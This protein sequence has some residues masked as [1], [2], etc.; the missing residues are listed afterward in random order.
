MSFLLGYWTLPIL[1]ILHDFEEM[2]FLPLWKRRSKFRALPNQADYF[3][4]TRDGSAFTVGVLEEFVILL[5]VS[6]VCSLTRGDELYLCFCVAYSLHFLIHYRMCFRF[7]G[8]VPGV[9]TVTLQVPRMWFIISH[10]WRINMLTV[11]CF[12]MVM[13]V[14]Y[15][16]LYVMHRLM[17]RIER[18]FVG[19][20]QG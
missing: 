17:P 19:Y 10:Y 9:V 15:G 5:T 4:E 20:A 3:G 11:V 2:V 1:F 13:V 18:R 7:R 6:Y 12:M 16:N 14:V 8:Y